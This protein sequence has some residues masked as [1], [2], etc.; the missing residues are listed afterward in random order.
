[1][2]PLRQRM[3]EDL[4]V[5]NFSPHT[6][7]AY[8]RYMARFARHFGC[9]PDRLG[10]EQIR[11]FQVYLATEKR[12][13]YGVMTQF[14][15]ALRFFYRVTMGKNW[16]IEKIPYPKPQR[17]LPIIL[18]REKIL[19][20]LDSISN[21]KHRAILTTCY[22]GGLRVSE[23]T[24]LRNKDID[25]SR[26]TIRIRQGKGKKDRLVPLSETLIH[27]LREYWRIVR[28][29][30]WLFPGR[31]ADRPITTRSVQRVFA[32]AREAARI[33]SKVTVHTLRHSFATHLLEAGTNVRT[34]QL[35]LGH[36]SL[37]TTA[38]YT[39]VSVQRLLETTSP[40]DLAEPTS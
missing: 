16:V 21:I 12:V 8:V 10:P 37:R 22:A 17:T 38:V 18:S 34:I 15:S 24:R 27:L 31:F 11:E 29:P 36:A 5:R 25:S 19:R 14:T 13:S 26:M 9:P 40:L 20:F 35:L 32:R 30:D 3:I 7:Q 6:E 33:D 4:R 1:M 28:P 23:V 39:H 2:T